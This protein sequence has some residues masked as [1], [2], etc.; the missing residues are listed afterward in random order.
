MGRIW[1]AIIRK[2]HTSCSNPKSLEDWILTIRSSVQEFFRITALRW[3]RVW[4]HDW[5]E[6]PFNNSGEGKVFVYSDMKFRWLREPNGDKTCEYCGS[7]HP[8]E[9][10][11]FVNKIILT[12]GEIGRIELNDNKDKVYIYREKVSDAHEGAIKFKLA[13]LSQ[14]QLKE[15]EGIINSALKISYNKF[16]A[17]M[18]VKAS[19]I[20]EIN[21]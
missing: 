9:F 21:G 11:K 20:G 3:Q 6:C 17:K 15:F 7:W 1:N 13:H 10:L 19:G 2:S 18:D 12:Q 4:N 14:G 16:M 5:V 8:D